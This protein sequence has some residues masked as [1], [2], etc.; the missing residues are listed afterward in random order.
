M[1]PPKQLIWIDNNI[2]VKIDRGRDARSSPEEKSLGKAIEDDLVGLVNDGHEIMVPP[3][4]KFEFLSARTQIR[5]PLL[6]SLGF[7]ED[8]RVVEVNRKQVWDWGEQG[9][10]A[11]L[12]AADADVIAQVRAG[13]AVRNI[14]NP[15]FLTRDG[16][17]TVIVMRRR[18][19]NAIEF[20][21]PIKAKI[22]ALPDT[23]KIEVPP[24]E[25]PVGAVAEEAFLDAAKQGLKAGLKGILSA[26]TI[27]GI[28]A[29][30]LMAYADRAAAQQA[31]RNIE[32]K[33]IEEGFAKGVAAS[34]MFWT[35][36]EVAS[37]LMYRVTNFRVEGLADAGGVLTMGTVIN[38]A[39]ACEN[40]AV[41]VGYFYGSDQ[42]WKW[43]KDML[44]KGAD[45][46][47]KYGYWFGDDPQALF[48]YDFIEKLGSVLRPSTDPIVDPHIN[49]S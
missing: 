3:R 42:S 29:T 10:K 36:G 31:I 33:F 30:V 13:A 9:R 37:E 44:G 17:G 40:Y 23:P 38:L 4:V 22:P 21:A 2:L 11:G 49:F 39:E 7:T 24:P 18:G 5:E 35:K 19:V 45:V 12:S 34:V 28:L 43:K 48:E 8:V 32:T 6:K 20:E 47:S 1:P 26:D 14:T 25:V 41:A 15:T 16:G 46:L 27:V